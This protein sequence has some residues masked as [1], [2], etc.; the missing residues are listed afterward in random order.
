MG[1]YMMAEAG[2]DPRQAPEVWKLLM[3]VEEEHGDP[4]NTT[5]AVLSTHP[6]HVQ[7]LK[8]LEEMVPEVIAASKRAHTQSDSKSKQPPRQQAIAP[9]Q[10]M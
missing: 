6:S 1:I 4:A 2:Y 8:R 10:R 5:M 7:R 9:S 3:K